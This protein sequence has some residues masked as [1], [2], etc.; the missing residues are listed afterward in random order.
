[1]AV[2]WYT[3]RLLVNKTNYGQER[4][5]SIFLRNNTKRTLIKSYSKVGNREEN[6]F[7]LYTAQ[8]YFISYFQQVI[9][10]SCLA[11]KKGGIFFGLHGKYFYKKLHYDRQ[12][13]QL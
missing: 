12:K 9:L 11:H 7:G 4:L 2:L 8:I 1:M 6:E 5:L 13:H 10:L 3:L